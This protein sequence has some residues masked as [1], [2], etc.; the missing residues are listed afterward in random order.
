VGPVLGVYTYTVGGDVAGG[1]EEGESS[2][3]K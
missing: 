3:L 2:L 1:G